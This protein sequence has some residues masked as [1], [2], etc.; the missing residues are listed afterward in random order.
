MIDRARGGTANE[1]ALTEQLC[2]GQRPL[3]AP[4][5]CNRPGRGLSRGYQWAASQRAWWPSRAP[6]PESRC[7]GPAPSSWAFCGHS[8]QL[9]HLGA[10]RMSCKA[11]Y[12]WA[13]GG[14]S[15]FSCPWIPEPRDIGIQT[16][17]LIIL[18]AGVGGR[19]GRL[20]PWE[21]VVS[22]SLPF[23]PWVTFPA[24]PLQH[25]REA[26]QCPQ[27]PQR[28]GVKSRSP[29]GGRYFWPSRCGLCWLPGS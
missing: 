8:N 24:S 18:P 23:L 27:A 21:W 7:V 5:A 6:D 14:S 1:R 10:Q 9:G 29:W 28:N 25:S 17:L 3:E 12:Y 4:K 13:M 26:V 15:R 19:A 2:P 20:R 16:L 22:L 11:G